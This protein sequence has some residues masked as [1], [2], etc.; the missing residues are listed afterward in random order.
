MTIEVNEYS[1]PGQLLKD[2][3]GYW[4]VMEDEEDEDDSDE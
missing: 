1:Y 4:N 3:P 2:D